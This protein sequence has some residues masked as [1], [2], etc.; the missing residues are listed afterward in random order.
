VICGLRGH[1]L[2]GA[3]AEELRPQD[4]LIARDYEGVRWLRCLRC[5]SWLP[6]ARPPA[7]T[8]LHPPDRGE[9]TIP[10]RGKGLREKAVLRLIAIERVFHVLILGLLGVAALA[11]AGNRQ[12]LR[13]AFYRILNALQG[14]VG[15]GQVETSGHVGF[16][17]D[18]DKLFSLSAGTIRTVGIVLLAYAVLEG[19]E[20]IGLWFT[21]RWAEYLTFV[22]TTI[23]LPLEIHEILRGGTVLKVVGF[24][25]NLAVVIYLLLAKRL[26][27]GARADERQ[28]T[29][30]TSW[31]AIERSTPPASKGSTGAPG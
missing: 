21:K 28:R 13:A 10:L 7:P 23:L 26:R 6:I 24:L 2:F 12:S 29:R 3:D 16:V 15:G 5:D 18:L 8:R 11:F 22:A 19:V 17:G 1:V 31:E 20:A 9:I 4:A 14:G 30:D 25:I 27:G